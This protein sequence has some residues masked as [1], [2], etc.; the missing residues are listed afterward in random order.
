MQRAWHSLMHPHQKFPHPTRQHHPLP[1]HYYPSCLSPPARGR[2]RGRGSRRGGRGSRRGGRSSTRGGRKTTPGRRDQHPEEEEQWS[3]NL[4]SV[5]VE[6]FT[7]LTG[8]K[9]PVS[10][11]PT[12]M[13]LS[14][15]TSQLIDH[16]VVETNRYAAVCIAASHKGDGLVPEWETNA[17][18]IKAY[19]GFSLL[20]AMNRLPDLYDYRS[21]NDTLHYFPVA[22]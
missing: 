1:H 18:E 20:M 2:G 9:V 6:P 11:N 8:P 3:S 19:L 12:E 13:F 7:R 21:T 17:E 16:I 5:R 14:F 22:S 10:S 4:T 15:F